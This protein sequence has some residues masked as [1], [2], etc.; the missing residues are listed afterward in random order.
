MFCKNNHRASEWW[1]EMALM[2][3]TTRW[4]LARDDWSLVIRCE[5]SY[6]AQTGV[7]HQ[8]ITFLTVL[9]ADSR[10]HYYPVQI[11]LQPLEIC[12]IRQKHPC[13]QDVLKIICRIEISLNFISAFT[14][15]LTLHSEEK[16]STLPILDAMWWCQCHV[17]RCQGV[18]NQ[19]PLF[20]TNWWW[21]LMK[22]DPW[23]NRRV[24]TSFDILMM[25]WTRVV[26]CV[27]SC[28]N[29]TRVVSKNVFENP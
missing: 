27:S 26:R 9:P 13:L 6:P 29:G 24:N 4:L 7:K 20:T 16:H 5:S 14:V 17:P 28:Q 25:C 10:V 19:P 21:S 15:W 18:P 1:Q 2:S 3:V 12:E 11:L 8:K 22:R 23:T